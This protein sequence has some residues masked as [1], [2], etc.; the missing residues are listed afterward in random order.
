MRS[1]IALSFC[2]LHN[3]PCIL[4]IPLLEGKESIFSNWSHVRR[5]FIV[6]LKKE[7]KIT[8]FVLSLDALGLMCFCDIQAI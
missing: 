2:N 7:E 6:D 8:I 4:I 1:F 5:E 3:D